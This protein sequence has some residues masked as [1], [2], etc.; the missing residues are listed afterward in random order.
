M[1]FLLKLPVYTEVSLVSALVVEILDA[2]EVEK[3]LSCSP[4]P[5][6]ELSEKQKQWR[7]IRKR[8]IL[9]S[10]ARSTTVN[11][12]SGVSNIF[13]LSVAMCCYC[14]CVLSSVV[15]AS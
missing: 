15:Q 11:T 12:V 1:Q 14:R 4:G 6:L 2:V 5:Q 9:D 7:I 13:L 8:Q 3:S 10:R